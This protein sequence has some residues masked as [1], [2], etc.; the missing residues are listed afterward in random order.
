MEKLTLTVPELAKTLGVGLNA[1]YDLIHIQGF[2]VI[3][4]GK[5]YV[6]PKTGLDEWLKRAG[7]QS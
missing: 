2:P 3:K 6:I 5:R 7:D 1:A 4:I